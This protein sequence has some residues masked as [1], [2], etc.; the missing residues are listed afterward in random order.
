M[1]KKITVT[2]QTLRTKKENLASKN[3]Q[4]SNKISKLVE[5]EAKLNQQWDGEAN[6]KFHAAFNSDKAQMDKFHAAI[7]KYCTSLEQI[8]KQYENAERANTQI[9]SKRTYH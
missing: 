6:D 5:A 1:A 7:Q 4:L 3:S 8:I 2:T 9:A